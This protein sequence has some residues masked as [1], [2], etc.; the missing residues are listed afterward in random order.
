VTSILKMLAVST[1]PFGLAF[2]AAAMAAP[3]NPLRDQHPRKCKAGHEQACD[4]NSPKL[5]SLI[6]DA[7]DSPWGDGDRPWGDHPERKC[8]PEREICYGD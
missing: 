2:S 7:A 6:G 8:R 5:R 1:L 4:K 3:D